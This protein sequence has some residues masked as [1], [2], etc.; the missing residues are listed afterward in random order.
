MDDLFEV[1]DEKKVEFQK[2]Y[3]T[4]GIE[5]TKVIITSDDDGMKKAQKK[6]EKVK[7]RLEIQGKA[8]Y[9]TKL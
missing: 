1:L 4:S 3:K 9:H 5:F 8:W 6:L 2:D 7:K